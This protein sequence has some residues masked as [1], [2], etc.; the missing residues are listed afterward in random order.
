MVKKILVVV[1]SINIEDSSG[2]KANV[3]LINNLDEAGFEVLVYH[4]TRKDIQL[5]NIKTFSVPEIKSSFNYFLS[6]FFRVVNRNFKINFTP[7]F[8]KRF[9]FSFTFF[10]DVQSIIK[11]LKKQSFEPDL[12]LTLSKGASF[13]PHYAVLKLPHLHDKWMAYVHDPFPFHYYPRPYNWIEPG[14]DKKEIFFR[15]ISEKAKYSAFPSQL[16][17]E[18]MSSYFSN[19]EKTG[20]I[21][22]HQNAKYEIQNNNFPTYFNAAKFNILHA[23]NLMKQ[24]PPKGLLEGFNTFLKKNPEARSNSSLILLGNAGDHTEVLDFFQ[25][26][27]PELYAYNGNK[28]F[29]EVF[30]IQKN[31]SVNVI[32]ESKSEVSPFLPAKFAHC[33]EAN[34]VIL[35]L[36]PYYSETRRLLGNDYPY[37]SEVDQA[38]KI[39]EIIEDL[40]QLW[41]KNPLSL[42]LNRRDLEDY[43]SSDYLKKVINKDYFKDAI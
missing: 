16:L 29:D 40:Y 22:P 31:A 38:E 21:I 9:G 4:Y 34:K 14:Y 11:A 24:R 2:S 28:T 8:E 13:R 1:D 43:L 37:W 39:A 32:L 25:K 10:N 7:F 5:K 41:K 18:W 20:I 23:G 15:E 27:I 19:F 6:R 3:A 42:N 30:L 12:V 35:S 26:E 33:V 36:A 17:K